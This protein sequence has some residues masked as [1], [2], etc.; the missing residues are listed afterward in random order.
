MQVVVGHFAY[1]HMSATLYGQGTG[2]FTTEEITE[3]KKEICENIN[4]LL[5]ASSRKRGS[6]GQDGMFFVLGGDGPTEAD[7]TLFGFVAAGL[8]CAA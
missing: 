6:G 4:A 2:R 8:V 1:R 7:T 5:S 3:F